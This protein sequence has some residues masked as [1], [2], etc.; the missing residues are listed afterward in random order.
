MWTDVVIVELNFSLM[1]VLATIWHVVKILFVIIL[2]KKI[3]RDY[4]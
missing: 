1:I 4:E 3:K 2:L